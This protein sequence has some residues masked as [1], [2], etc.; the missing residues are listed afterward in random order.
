MY[1][2]QVYLKYKIQ[3]NICI[4]KIKCMLIVT[5]DM[6]KYLSR[7]TRILKRGRHRP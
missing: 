4:F 1:I 7:Y 2:F 3:L 5:V 6:L